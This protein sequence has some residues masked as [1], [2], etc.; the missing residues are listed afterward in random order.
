MQVLDAANCKAN[1]PLRNVW[2]L[3]QLITEYR[4]FFFSFSPESI[5]NNSKEQNYL[6]LSKIRDG[7]LQFQNLALLLLK[8]TEGDTATDFVCLALV[9]AK[10]IN[11]AK[12]HENKILF[13]NL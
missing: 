2:I 12:G 11:A 13:I 10:Y 8:L 6:G 5:H 7:A 4:S 1:N 9:S 3:A